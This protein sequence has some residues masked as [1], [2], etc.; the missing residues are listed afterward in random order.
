M[1]PNIATLRIENSRDELSEILGEDF[2]N[3]TLNAVSF[4]NQMTV[5]E[6]WKQS[7]RGTYMLITISKKQ[8]EYGASVHVTILENGVIRNATPAL[9][10]KRLLSVQEIVGHR[11]V[12]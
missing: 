3:C 10:K 12:D 4:P 7:H 6:F 2:L 9:L 5:G 11:P 1:E 8:P